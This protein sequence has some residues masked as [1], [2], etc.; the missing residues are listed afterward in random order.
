MA[1]D[2]EQLARAI[3]AAQWRHHRALD[4][5]LH[6]IGSTI[7]QCD[8]LRAIANNPGASAHDLATATFQSDQAFGTLATRMVAHGLIER[9]PGHGRRIAHH[10]T[11]AG[12]GLLARGREIARELFA[13]SFAD[14]SER[15]RARLL[16]SLERVGPPPA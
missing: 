6:A 9:R 11:P 15:D 2:I 7:V 5:R 16:A 13:A 14:L 12:E 10:L 1:V 4:T 3:K 8:A